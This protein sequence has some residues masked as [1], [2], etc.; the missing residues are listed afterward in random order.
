M[1]T[2]PETDIHSIYLDNELPA[3]YVADYEAH[4]AECPKC[5]AKLEKL[6]MMH[7]VFSSDSKSMELSQRDLDNSFERLQ[8][9]LSY[10]RHTK[11]ERVLTF[12]PK[13]AV[14]ALAGAAA[15]LAIFVLPAKFTNKSAPVQEAVASVPQLALVNKVSYPS[16]VPIHMDGEISPESLGNLFADGELVDTDVGI[17][18]IRTQIGTMGYTNPVITPV[19]MTTGQQMQ[20]DSMVLKINGQDAFILQPIMNQSQPIT[21]EGSIDE[22]NTFS[23]EFLYGQFYFKAQGGGK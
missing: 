5:R 19:G 17:S 20:Q 18:P 16:N 2:C 3:A 6:R 9:R 22:Q 23:V 1:S 14:Y 21:G 13:K 12:S 15:A 4:I 8:A 11:N 7:S 10:S